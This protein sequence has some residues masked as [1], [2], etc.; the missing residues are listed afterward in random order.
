MAAKEAMEN[1]KRTQALLCEAHKV[2]P[3]K[4]PIRD[5]ISKKREMFMLQYATQV[6][7]QEMKRLKELAAKEETQL[8]LAEKKLE[9]DAALFD[10]F[11]KESDKNSIAAVARAEQAV[12]HR[13]SKEDEL[14]CL[15][16]QLL[17]VQAEV[18]KNEAKLREYREYY[19]FLESLVPDPYKSQRTSRRLKSKQEKLKRINALRAAADSEATGAQKEEQKWDSSRRATKRFSLPR[20]VS[21]TTRRSSVQHRTSE[22]GSSTTH[23]SVLGTVLKAVFKFQRRIQ[24][25][26]TSQ[27]PFTPKEIDEISSDEEEELEPYFTDPQQLL[28]LLKE[29]EE[30]NLGLIQNCQEAEETYEGLR[31]LIQAN[32][33]RNDRET[34]VLVKQIERLRALLNAENE[35]VEELKGLIHPSSSGEISAKEQMEAL[36]KLHT[37]ISDVYKECIRKDGTSLSSI[38]MLTAIEEEIEELYEKLRKYPPDLVKAVRVEKELARRERVRMEVKELEHQYQEERIERAL[39]RAKAAPKKLA[40]RRVIDRSRPPKCGIKLEEVDTEDS[41]EAS[42]YAYFFT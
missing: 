19:E 15:N 20:R 3:E 13:Q 33:A 2:H 39:Q 1:E 32:E 41:T 38:Q 25:K 29:L 37:E 42:E 21:F 7:Q 10:E 26:P 17:Q 4:G 27:A 40:G 16:S 12:K 28:T 6:K 14:K 34:G 18:I 31:K 24:A 9:L 5:F 11:I 36:E 8:E 30:S 22:G 35:R 23:P